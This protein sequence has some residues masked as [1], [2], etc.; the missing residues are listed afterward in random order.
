MSS[1]H[2][3]IANKIL[4]AKYN[5]HKHCAADDLPLLFRYIYDFSDDLEFTL[6]IADCLM[7]NNLSEDD[8]NLFR[9]KIHGPL[10]FNLLLKW[11]ERLKHPCQ[12]KGG[13][14]MTYPKKRRSLKERFLDSPLGRGYQWVARRISDKRKENLEHKL[15][16]ERGRNNN[17]GVRKYR[18]CSKRRTVKSQR[19]RHQHRLQR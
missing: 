14:T 1:L 18:R 15:L 3:D 9:R 16:S 10:I 6:H 17:F 4:E 12:I 5:N 7:H 19:Q 2:T 11:E 13:K 8:K